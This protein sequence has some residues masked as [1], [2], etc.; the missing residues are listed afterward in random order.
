MKKKYLIIS[1]LFL[2][3]CNNMMDD[4][5]PHNMTDADSYLSSF[6]NLVN[7]TSG[8]YGGLV[9]EPIG[10]TDIYS[11]Y[12]AYH[13]LGEFRTN[14]LIFAEAFP[15]AYGSAAND[16]LRC[17][18]AHFFLNSDQKNQSYAYPLWANTLRLILTASRNIIAIDELQNTT[19]NPEE[20]A[21]LSRLKG[22]NAFIRGLLIFNATNVFGRPYWET[23]SENLGIPLDI[24]ATGEDLQRST[25]QQCYEQ[26]IADFKTAASCL[27]DELSNRTFANKAAAYGLLSRIYLYMGG[28]PE[29]P[30]PTYNQLAVDYAD[31][32]FLLKNDL[33][34]LAQGENLA[35]LYEDLNSKPNQEI[36]FELNLSNFPT[37]LSNVIHNFYSWNGYE[38]YASTSV[39]CCVVSTDYEEIMDKDKDLRWKYFTEP[40][41][42]F[43]GR[44]CTTKYNGGK[45]Y[46]FDDYCY[47]ICPTVF[48]R[49]AEV[50]LNRA[51]AYC[52]LG[53]PGK[54]LKDLN[55]IRERAG[56]EPLS[57][58]SRDA[59]FQEIFNER[60]R[61]LAFEAQTYYDYMRNGMTMKRKETST[62]YSQYTGSQY[63]EMNPRTSRR[64]VC[65]IPSEELILNKNLVQNNY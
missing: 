6:N 17:P 47:F 3:A 57:G 46:L 22:E 19:L 5:R 27:P 12:G 23:P 14:N 55:T 53:E 62:V 2:S 50:I 63:N 64:S 58:I 24:N 43:P 21:N 59:L 61:E 26:V 35:Y 34:E 25:V 8:L 20:K 4:M 60:R 49:A 39:Y 37:D 48:L 36:L 28:V 65:L 54:A 51:E 11:Y 56:L 42:R 32:T 40:S 30:D 7:A 1:L 16:Y 38:S 10:Y 45:K 18:D 33:V 31:S 41:E 52:K 15:T 9:R 29:S 44:F 13:V